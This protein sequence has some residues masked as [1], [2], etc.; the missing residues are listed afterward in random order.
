[1]SRAACATGSNFNARVAREGR[2]CGK[3]AALPRNVL[4]ASEVDRRPTGGEALETSQK[5]L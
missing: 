5:G 2:Q 4:A 3:L 1:M